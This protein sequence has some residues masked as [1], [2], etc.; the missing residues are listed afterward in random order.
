MTTVVTFKISGRG[1]ETDAPTVDDWLEQIADYLDI[2]RGVERALAEDGQ[3]AIDWRVLNASKTSPLSVQIGAFP[4][5]YATNIDERVGLVVRHTAAGLHALER[6]PERPIY[7]NDYVLGKVEQVFERVTNGLALSEID[8]GAAAPPLVITPSIAVGAAKNAR[9]AKAP[10]DRP[11]K[12]LG[13]IEG[14]FDSVGKD[15][16]GHRL[17]WIR[18]RLTGNTIKC[19]LDGPALESIGHHEIHEVFRG[20][21]LLVIGTIYYKSLGHISQI[22]ADQVRFFPAAGELPGVDDILDKNFTGGL[23]SEE[24]LDRLR[25]GKLS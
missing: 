3:G 7:F 15:G 4:T 6:V 25:D 22:Q 23:S 2:L 18:H 10:P 1:A 12:E 24:Y 14:Y 9:L 13:A 5:T 16:Y 17:L 20:R 11:Y 8:F 19:T 21:R